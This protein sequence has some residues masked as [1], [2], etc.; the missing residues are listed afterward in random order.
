MGVDDPYGREVVSPKKYAEDSF[1][2]RIVGEEGTNIRHVCPALLSGET[3]CKLKLTLVDILVR[4]GW[5]EK[6][7]LSARVG[8]TLKL[9]TGQKFQVVVIDGHRKEIHIEEIGEGTRT[10]MD[11]QEGRIS[12]AP[13]TVKA[14]RYVYQ[15]RDINEKKKSIT[16][17]DLTLGGE[18]SR[19]GI[20]AFINELMKALPIQ[21]IHCF[22]E[23]RISNE[24]LTQDGSFKPE[25]GVFIDNNVINLHVDPWNMEDPYY[26]KLMLRTFYHELGHAL[27]KHLMGSPHP[28][29]KWKNAMTSDG[30]FISK[31][32]EL[33]KYAKIPQDSGEVEDFACAME[34]Y[35]AS[36]GAVH[37]ET[38]LRTACRTRF[39]LLDQIFQDLIS[40]RSQGSR[41]K[42][43][44]VFGIGN[45]PNSLLN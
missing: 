17:Y 21:L 31:Y 8:D 6:D 35:L 33:M 23:I 42:I 14:K 18:E 32:S 5:N 45:G 44:R 37:R 28:G 19:A 20:N 1:S 26:R 10:D 9:I 24:S 2:G 39:E 38:E 7:V 30:N 43:L 12:F 34:L 15:A 25:E 40:E 4:D 13:R 41:L 27:A 16:I 36:D 29:R 22:D 3:P 11:G